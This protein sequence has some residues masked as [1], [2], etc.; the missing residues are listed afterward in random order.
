MDRRKFAGFAVIVLIGVAIAYVRLRERGVADDV[1]EAKA[2]SI[3]AEVD[4]YPKN[5]RFYES[6]S[7]LAHAGAFDASFEIV[8]RDKASTVDEDLYMA[9]FFERLINMARNEG[10]QDIVKALIKLRDKH[11]I[12]R[13]GGT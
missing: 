8:A 13:P 9:E 6:R 2:M 1:V 3:L 4:D 10:R 11:E 7:Q 5:E 12:P